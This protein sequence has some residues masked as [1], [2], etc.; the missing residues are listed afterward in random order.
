M[1][2]IFKAIVELLILVNPVLS[3]KTPA[4]LFALFDKI[5]VSVMFKFPVDPKRMA[6]PPPLP[7]A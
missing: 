1:H 7:V 3:A 4:P 2:T 6:I 5:T